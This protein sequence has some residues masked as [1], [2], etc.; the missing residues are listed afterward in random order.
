[1][2]MAEFATAVKYE[3]PIKVFVIKNNVLGMI[4]WEQMVML[5]NPEYGIELH[6]IDFAMFARSCGAVGLSVTEPKACGDIIE[7][8]LNSPGPALVEAVVDPYEPPLPGKIKPEQALK[9]AESLARGEPRR[10]HI[11]TTILED[12]V[13]EL[14]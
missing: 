3:L 1:M 7:Q 13:R 2:L 5:G 9:L 6:P 14:V 8:A 11:A 12:K 4:R 10:M